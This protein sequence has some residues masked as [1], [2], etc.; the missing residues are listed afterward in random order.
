VSYYLPE[1]TVILECMEKSYDG[2]KWG[3]ADWYEDVE[4]GIKEALESRKE[5]WTTGWV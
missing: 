5:N 3:L 1:N 4:K 2:S